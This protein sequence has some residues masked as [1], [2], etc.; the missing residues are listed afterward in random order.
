LLQRVLSSRS[1]VLRFPL[2]LNMLRYQPYT[3]CCIDK[4]CETEGSATSKESRCGLIGGFQIWED[5][6]G[7]GDM[8]FLDSLWTAMDEA[9]TLQDCDVYSYKS[10]G[11]DDPF[12]T[13]PLPQQTV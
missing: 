5:T 3:E 13:E 2:Q 8:P 7:C 9:I 6:P 10:D 11:E 1:R 4:N 12:G